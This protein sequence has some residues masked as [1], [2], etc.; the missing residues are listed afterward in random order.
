MKDFF[1]AVKDRRTYYGISKASPVSDDRI[2]EIVHFAVKHVPSAF[3]SQSGRAVLLLGKS[4]DEFWSMVK[5]SLRKI[6]P[7]DKFAPRRK[8]STVS[9]AATVRCSSSRIRGRSK[10]CR[11]S[12]PPM[13]LISPCGPTIHRECFSIL[14]G[15]GWNQRDSVPRCSITLQWWKMMSGRNGTSPPSGA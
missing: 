2:K 4:S 6:V 8:R 5:E 15:P 13:P 7:A 12:S 1:A 9:E 11:S 10:T 14:S 3:N